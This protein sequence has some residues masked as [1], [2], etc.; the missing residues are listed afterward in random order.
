MRH[1]YPIHF[2]Y[3]GSPTDCA[4]LAKSIHP[5][6]SSPLISGMPMVPMK[7]IWSNIRQHRLPSLPPCLPLILHHLKIYLQL[8]LDTVKAHM[9]H[10]PLVTAWTTMAV[11]RCIKIKIHMPHNSRSDIHHMASLQ[12]AKCPPQC[13][14]R[15]QSRVVREGCLHVTWSEVSAPV[16]SDSPILIIKLV[17]GLSCKIWVCEPRALSGKSIYDFT[18]RREGMY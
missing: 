2:L 10:H 3:A 9:G 17:F 11:D 14:L 6:M 18:H 5:S 12:A 7:S 16:R 4:H 15:S 1:V 8:I 13:H